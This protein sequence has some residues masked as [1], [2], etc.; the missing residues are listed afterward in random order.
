MER[1]SWRKE[2]FALTNMNAD[3][4]GARDYQRLVLQGRIHDNTTLTFHA[5]DETYMRK[6][7]NRIRKAAAKNRQSVQFLRENLQVSVTFTTLPTV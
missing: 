4:F 3:T 1:P 6:F 2:P 7:R 5:T